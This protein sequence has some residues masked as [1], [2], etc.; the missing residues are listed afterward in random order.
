MAVGFFDMFFDSEYRQRDDIND[1]RDRE[2]SLAG[3][4]SALGQQNAMLRQQVHELSMVVNVLVKMLEEAG[5]VEAKILRYRV[6]AELDAQAAQRSNAPGLGA[7]LY[8]APADDR[9]VD[10]PPPTTP[11]TCSRCGAQVPANLT[12]ITA[13]GVVCDRCGSER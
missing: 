12:V 3:D 10:A 4:L 6:E 7:S 1:L 11:T 5:H 13:D 8:G 2:S 9:P